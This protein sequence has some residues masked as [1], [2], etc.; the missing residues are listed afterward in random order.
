MPRKHVSPFV[1]QWCSSVECILAANSCQTGEHDVICRPRHFTTILFFELF[2]TQLEGSVHLSHCRDKQA[3]RSSSLVNRLHTIRFNMNMNKHEWGWCVY[4]KQSLALCI[5]L[6]SFSRFS[7]GVIHELRYFIFRFD[8][9]YR[10]L[11]FKWLATMRTGSSRDSLCLV[12]LHHLAC[13]TCGQH[14]LWHLTLVQQL[15]SMRARLTGDINCPGDEAVLSELPRLSDVYDHSFA[16]GQELLQLLISH[17]C[18][19]W[20]WAESATQEP[21]CG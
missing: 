19:R 2:R 8:A 10:D 18:V 3:E 9:K 1:S 20:R 12:R 11:T 5:F 7:A 21:L 6:M 17:I 14:K 15:F 4:L 16:T 13:P